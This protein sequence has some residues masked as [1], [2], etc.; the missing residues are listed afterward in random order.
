MENV[1]TAHPGPTTLDELELL[2]WGQLIPQNTQAQAW[3]DLLALKQDDCTVARYY[4][5]FHKLSTTAKAEPSS[6]PELFRKG[7][8]FEIQ[9]DLTS[10]P[11]E[12]LEK[13]VNLATEVERQRRNLKQLTDANKRNNFGNKNRLPKEKA[14]KEVVDG[15]SSIALIS[16]DVNQGLLSMSSNK[17]S[18]AYL[19]LPLNLLTPKKIVKKNIRK[20]L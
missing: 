20:H 1:K 2:V 17:D 10:H 18:S 3:A 9:R 4:V 11:P 15:D 14:E 5:N 12:S 8:N 13:E 16:E 19:L 7:L 6:L